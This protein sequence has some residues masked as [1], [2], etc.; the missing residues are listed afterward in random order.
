MST[1]PR[2]RLNRASVIVGAL[3]ALAA[4]CPSA[5]AMSGT[6]AFP[7]ST[8]DTSA[9]TVVF[10]F[11]AGF[12]G[13]YRLLTAGHSANFTSTTGNHSAQFG[14]HYLNLTAPVD[15]GTGTKDNLVAHGLSGTIISLHSIPFRGRHE[16]GLPKLALA[17]F[18][19]VAPAAVFSLSYNYISLPVVLGLGL[20]ITPHKVISITPWLEAS[21]SVNFDTII[22][23]YNPESVNWNDSVTVDP[24]TG[25]VTGVDLDPNMVSDIIQESVEIDISGGMTLRGGLNIAIH[26]GRVDLQLSGAAANIGPGF[27]RTAVFYGGVQLVYAWDH[28]PPTV[29]PVEKRLMYESC[30]DVEK[31]FQRCPAYQKLLDQ[32]NPPCPDGAQRAFGKC[33]VPAT[34]QALPATPAP[35]VSPPQT[36]ADLADPRVGGEPAAPPLPAATESKPCTSEADCGTGAHCVNGTCG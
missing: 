10:E 15:I 18:Y 24:T 30:E 19:G 27:G 31:R 23:K 5:H 13:Q 29:L 4:V 9:S 33:P 3:M 7:V 36:K 14:M 25:E 8:F 11:N 34:T 26:I 35:L 22:K 28:P 32:A 17:I 21:P 1:R 20:P 6:H 2:R 16:N 12:G